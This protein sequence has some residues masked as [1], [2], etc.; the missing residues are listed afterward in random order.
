MS[1]N[2]FYKKVIVSVAGATLL[3]IGLNQVPKNVINSIPT[4]VRAAQKAKV[5]GAN[6]AVYKQTDQKVIKTKKIIRVGEKIR[7][8]G[9][10]WQ[11]PM[12]QS[13]KCRWQKASSS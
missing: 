12:Y 8:Y 4:E 2:N 9:Q 13:F 3:L 1:K 10:D 7:V 6:S 5:I 11:K